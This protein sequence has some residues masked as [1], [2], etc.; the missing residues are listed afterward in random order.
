MIEVKRYFEEV[1][2]G[3]G[4]VLG[5]VLFGGFLV[6]I[7]IESGGRTLSFGGVFLMIWK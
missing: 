4:V 2:V 5:V 3:G 6:G 1:M 7:L